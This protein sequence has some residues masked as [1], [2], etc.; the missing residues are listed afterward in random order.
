MKSD[1]SFRTI[2]DNERVRVF[3]IDVPPLGSTQ[4]D[5]HAHD[6]IILSLGKSNFQLGEGSRLYP[7]QLDDG[8]MQVMKG[9]WPHRATNLANAT[10]RLVEVE[11]SR[12]IHPERPICG[13]AGREC[14]DG[15]FGGNAA[16][17]FTHSTLFETDTVKLSRLL[18]NP[19]VTQPEDHHDHGHLLLALDDL[20]LGDAATQ[21]VTLKA[22]D[23]RWYSSSATH[24]L[25]NLEHADA[26]L[27]TIDLK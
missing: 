10:L 9:G 20:E 23:A 4:L 17:T 18:L 3:T 11:I 26:R 25:R 21:P 8:E 1:P 16:G 24:Q 6:Y 13:L 15:K 27:I 19:G 2:L 7:M 14:V 5:M 12:D 22:G